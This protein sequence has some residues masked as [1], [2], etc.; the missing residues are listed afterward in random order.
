MIDAAT[1]HTRLIGE[2]TPE[3]ENDLRNALLHARSSFEYY[4]TL[5]EQTGIS[6]ESIANDNPLGLLNRLPLLHEGALH[7]LTRDSLNLGAP[8]INPKARWPRI[9]R[10]SSVRTF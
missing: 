2:V 1:P 7:E 9:S 5:F 10:I 3:T 6:V 4:A 8:I